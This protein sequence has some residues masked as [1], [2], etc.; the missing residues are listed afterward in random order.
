MGTVILFYSSSIHTF[1]E[2]SIITMSGRIAVDGMLGGIVDGGLFSAL[3][4]SRSA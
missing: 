1:F 3:M 4:P 2:R